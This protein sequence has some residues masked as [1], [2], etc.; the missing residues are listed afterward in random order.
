MS[1]AKAKKSETKKIR[2]KQIG[3]G[4][5]CPV[6]MRETLKA[7]GLGVGDIQMPVALEQPVPIYPEI[8]RQA[9]IQGTVHLRC[10]VGKTGLVEQC[11]VT[12]HLT[13]E[14][15]LASE[16]AVMKW[17]YTPLRVKGAPAAVYIDVILT[18]S[19]RARRKH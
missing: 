5:G 19:L 17:K 18:F 13:P 14:C 2:I 10:I 1:P 6:E 12:Q 7:L 3:S 15:D 16:T 8:S 9:R 11:N 4:I